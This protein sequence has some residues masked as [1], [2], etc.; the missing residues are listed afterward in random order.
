[1][2]AVLFVLI[3]L[4]VTIANGVLIYD[5]VIEI[6][7]EQDAKAVSGSVETLDQQQPDALQTEAQEQATSNQRTKTQSASKPQAQAQ[8]KPKQSKPARQT[9]STSNSDS[10]NQQAIE[11]STWDSF[12]E[13][14]KQ[15][16]D[17]KVF[18]SDVER[19]LKQCE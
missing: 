18:C 17:K 8:E 16:S 14:V 15:G 13:S 10:N 11:K 2:G 6:A 9:S 12:K 5:G 1:M 7:A 4:T 3:A 19:S